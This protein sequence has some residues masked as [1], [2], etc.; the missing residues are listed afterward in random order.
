MWIDLL[1]MIMCASVFNDEDEVIFLDSPDAPNDPNGGGKKRVQCVRNGLSS[2]G[3]RRSSSI[4]LYRYTA[5][6]N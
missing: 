2:V 1:L 5:I 3:D 4:L 6:R